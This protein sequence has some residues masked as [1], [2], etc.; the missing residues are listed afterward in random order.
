M[1]LYVMRHGPAEDRAPSGRDFDRTL[2]RAGRAVVERAAP[3]LHQA[4]GA[5]GAAPLRVL[6]SPYHR[7]VETAELV[8]ALFGRE[9]EIVD[10]L[11]ADG[12]V[13]TSLVRDV[14]ANGSD[15]LLV[16][17][18]PIVEQLVRTLVHPTSPPL[19]AGFRTA[20]IV[21]L[22]HEDARWHVRHVLDPHSLP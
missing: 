3:A 4:P 14:H 20:T 7:A 18:Q 1:R 22:E 6:T 15:A 10:D 19:G 8:G 11:R 16:G 17:H 13:P 12:D 2:T 5:R 21:T 9:P